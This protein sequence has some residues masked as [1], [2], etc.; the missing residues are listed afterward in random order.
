MA[1]IV[2]EARRDGDRGGGWGDATDTHGRSQSIDAQRHPSDIGAATELP[3]RTETLE[4]RGTRHETTRLRDEGAV[5]VTGAPPCDG[6]LP[7]APRALLH[8]DTSGPR[9]SR[10]AGAAL[11]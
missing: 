3:C 10:A 4:L 11:K 1:G 7:Q 6:P 2:R 8:P 9:P 5:S